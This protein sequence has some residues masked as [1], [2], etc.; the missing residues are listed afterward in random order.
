MSPL[1]RLSDAERDALAGEHARHVGAVAFGTLPVRAALASVA[2][3]LRP[4]T[5]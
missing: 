4:P 2:N 3:V 1:D 5:N